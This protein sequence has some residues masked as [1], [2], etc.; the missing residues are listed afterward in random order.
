MSAGTFRGG[1]AWAIL[2]GSAAGLPA[3]AVALAAEARRLS[4]ALGGRAVAL[5]FGVDAE[6]AAT[7]GRA[8]DHVLLAPALGPDGQVQLATDLIRRRGAA[9][10]LVED[11]ARGLAGRLA[12]RLDA[13]P[14]TG[15]A[16][17]GVDAD[18]QLFFRRPVYGNAAS[19][20]LR[21][22]APPAVASILEEALAP[23][24]EA[25]TTGAVESLTEPHLQERC[26]ALRRERLAV[27]EFPLAQAAVVVAGGLG[28]G[29][30]ENVA[31]L[32]ELAEVLGGTVAATR[33]VVDRGWLPAH[34][35]VGQSGAI[36]APRVYIACGISG[37]PQHLAG[38]RGA[39]T[40]IAVNVDPGAPIMRLADVPIVGDV[41][42]VLPALIRAVRQ[43][44]PTPARLL[45]SLP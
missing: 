35:Q 26:R 33:P 23:A 38:M 22:H 14:L 16:S 41:R 43:R 4:A 19:A 7:L 36:V 12:A 37:A 1:D 8:V 28:L 40:V 15:C 17:V 20:T 34:R 27:R 11:A 5:A 44:R 42:E 31:L 32:E 39:Q 2:R 10:V 21:P 9:L 13:A 45:E 24:D 29:G 3:P 30:P 18:G 6:A 25:G